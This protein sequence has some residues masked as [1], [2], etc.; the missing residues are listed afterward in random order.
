MSY[1]N[2]KKE[3]LVE[4]LV[5]LSSINVDLGDEESNYNLSAQIQDEM[6]FLSAQIMDLDGRK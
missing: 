3:E 6:D 1:L 2:K 4:E 5:S